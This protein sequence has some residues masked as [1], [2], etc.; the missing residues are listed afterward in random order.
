MKIGKKTRRIMGPINK[1][2]QSTKPLC[3]LIDVI[4]LKTALV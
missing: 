1:R 3:F 2:I 4:T